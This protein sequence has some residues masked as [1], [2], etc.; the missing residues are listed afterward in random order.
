M[1]QQLN[2]QIIQMKT[3]IRKKRKLEKQLVDYQQE[4]ILMEETIA[5][6]ENR[7]KEEQKDVQ[8]LEGISIK[9]FFS[10]IT[11]T[12][13]EKLDKENRE[14]LAVQLQL[15]EAKKTKDDINASIMETNTKLK[16]VRH[17]E[18][19]YEELLRS[20]EKMIQESD[21]LYADELYRLSEEE[22]DIEVYIR[23][24]KEAIHAGKNASQALQNAYQSLDDAKGWGTLDMFGGGML[25]SAIKHDHMDKASDY[26]HLAQ[27]RMRTFQKELLD[28]DDDVSVDLDVSG[29]LKFADFFF[30]G[31]IVDWMV[32]G[33]INDSREQVHNQ[34]SKVN[35]ILSE[36]KRNLSDNQVKLT[37]IQTNRRELIE[38]L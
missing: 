30:D 34:L 16:S 29:L 14:V 3:N 26:I 5:N 9:N 38:G 27:S 25:S 23:E 18:M 7:L 20:K 6:L 37:S 24:V 32:Q 28:I 4:L 33:R 21:S 8:K 13:Y 35:R 22:G 31:F 10:T 17:S 12:K 11:G 2:D 19:E 36:L 15:E 1:Y